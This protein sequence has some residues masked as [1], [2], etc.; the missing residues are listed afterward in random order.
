MTRRKNPLEGTALGRMT[1]QA[2]DLSAA[3]EAKAATKEPPG[4]N[5]AVRRLQG[6]GMQ[7][8]DALG[9]LGLYTADELEV[10]RERILNTLLPGVRHRLERRLGLLRF[11][12]R[13]RTRDALRAELAGF[14]YGNA[15]TL[16]IVAVE[17]ERERK[18]RRRTGHAR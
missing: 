9:S 12:M 1:E 18:G 16:A 4:W 14:A 11:L 7:V 6:A 17:A 3:R 13:R 15:Y 10:L 2:V 8:E 5:A